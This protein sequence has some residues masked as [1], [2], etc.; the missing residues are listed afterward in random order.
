LAQDVK[1]AGG[2]RMN[3]E[4]AL[5]IINGIERHLANQGMTEE[6]YSLDEA[7]VTLGVY[8]QPDPIT[9]LVPCG[10]GGKAY[11]EKTSDDLYPSKVTCSNCHMSTDYTSDDDRSRRDWNQAMGYKGGAE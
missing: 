2:G 1:S 11:F 6:E 10:C 5:E 8:K 9:G 3:R 7:L 4:E